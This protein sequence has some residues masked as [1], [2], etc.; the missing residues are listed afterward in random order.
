MNRDAIFSLC[1][2]FRYVLG[3]QWNAALPMLV[4]VMLNPSIATADFDDPTIRKCVAFAKMMGFG[5]I[6]VVNL[7]AYRATDPHDLR[8]AGYQ[9]GEENDAHIARA[10]TNNRNV[11]CAWGAHARGLARPAEVLALLRRLGVKPMA[12]A[13]T[14]DGIPRHPL[15]LSYDD[16][17]GFARRMVEML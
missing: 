17:S 3:R 13:F 4:F 16:E 5:G 7:F 8:R 9:V 11:V 14:G 10:V 12:I 1:G 2:K 15:M 6:V